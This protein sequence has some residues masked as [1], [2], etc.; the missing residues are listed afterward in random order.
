[1]PQPPSPAT[2]LPQPCPHTP[3]TTTNM[4]ASAEGAEMMTWRGAGQARRGRQVAPHGA[5]HACMPTSQPRGH[6]RYAPP[7]PTFLAPPLRCAAALSTVVYTPVLSHTYAA[8]DSPHGISPASLRQWGGVWVGVGGGG[9]VGVGGGGGGGG[10]SAWGPAGPA[11]AAQQKRLA[12]FE[13]RRV[14]GRLH[15]LPQAAFVGPAGL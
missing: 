1:M 3:L 4:G 13:L 6:W 8:P 15:A 9:G 5:A 11:C 7:R 10:E 12:P 2:A 14:E